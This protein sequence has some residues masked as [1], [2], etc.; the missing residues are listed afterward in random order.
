MEVKTGVLPGGGDVGSDILELIF[1]DDGRRWYERRI[2]FSGLRRVY[3]LCKTETCVC[4]SGV[5]MGH[6]LTSTS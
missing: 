3:V 2:Y 5:S 4:I 1:V 6:C